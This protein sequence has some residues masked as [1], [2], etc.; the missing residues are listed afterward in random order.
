VAGVNTL[1]AMPGR[2]T[3]WTERL[4]LRPFH[5][6]DCDRVAALC[7]DR[8]IA[9]TT[10]LIPHPY[11][12]KDA[13]W[14]LGTHQEQYDSGKGINFAVDMGGELVGAVGLRLEPDHGRA[15]IGYW[16]GVPYW[17][18]GYAS[19]SAREVVRWGLNE[20]GLNR[21]YAYHFA[22]NAASGRVLQKAGM[23][24]EGMQRR[25]VRKWDRYEDCVMY[26]AVRGD[27]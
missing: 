13:E 18:K 15:E 8:R 7:A 1:A 22:R 5:M 24:H 9:D 21:V 2:P 12:L 25:H 6:T 16:I 10:L 17:G 14:W 26:G 27:V 19:E 3:L 4:T 11:T 23:R 20:L